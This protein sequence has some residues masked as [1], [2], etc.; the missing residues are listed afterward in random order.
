MRNPAED[1]LPEWDVLLELLKFLRIIG[2]I[3]SKGHI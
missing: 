1:L 2:E 3:E